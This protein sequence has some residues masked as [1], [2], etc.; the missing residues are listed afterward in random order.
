MVA[1]MVRC[2][3]KEV[4]VICPHRWDCLYHFSRGYHINFLSKRWFVFVA[5]KLGCFIR[6]HYSEFGLLLSFPTEITAHLVKSK[7][8]D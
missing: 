1:E 2:S 8:V 7:G 6:V 5:E 3:S 4:L